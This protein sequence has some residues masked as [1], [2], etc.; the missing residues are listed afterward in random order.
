[1]LNAFKTSLQ[2]MTSWYFYCASKATQ[3][4]Q[5]SQLVTHNR[6]KPEIWDINSG[7]ADKHRDCQYWGTSN[8]VLWNYLWPRRDGLYCGYHSI[9]TQFVLLHFVMLILIIIIFTSTISKL[10]LWQFMT[11]YN[12]IL[13]H[14]YIKIWY[15]KISLPMLIP[16]FLSFFQQHPESPS[17]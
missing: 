11:E 7:P 8:T 15:L 4:Q 3:N 16:F 17:L 1:M 10:S 14:I 6:H 9:C 5:I 12:Y 2:T 13:K